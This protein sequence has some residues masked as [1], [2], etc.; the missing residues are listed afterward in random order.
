MLML[1]LPPVLER[2]R[3]YTWTRAVL[4]GLG[5]A[6]VGILAVSLFRLAPHALPDAFGKPRSQSA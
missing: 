1:A 4:R 3:T 5:P 6:G 2:V